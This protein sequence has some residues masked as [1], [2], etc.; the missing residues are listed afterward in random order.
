MPKRTL[1]DKFG[2]VEGGQGLVGKPD[3]PPRIAEQPLA[4]LGQPR[5]APVA[6]EDR[7]ADPLLQPPHL[8][9]DR[10]LGLEDDVGGLGEAAG[11]GDGDEG[12]EL[13]E[14]EVGGHAGLLDM[15]QDP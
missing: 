15:H 5:G 4:V 7:L 12:P 8:H 3:H 14:V 11:F 1:P 9:R 13:V 2:F 10:R 6:H